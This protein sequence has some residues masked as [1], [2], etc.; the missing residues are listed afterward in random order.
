MA[1]KRELKKNIHYIMDELIAEALFLQSI[2]TPEEGLKIDEIIDQ[3]IETEQELISRSKHQG[4]KEIKV[5][6]K[7]FGKIHQDLCSFVA[8]TA[9]R[10]KTI[11]PAQ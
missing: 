4:S 10:L 11:H 6:Q 5:I 9:N 2:T 8:E 1:N 7:H 3:I